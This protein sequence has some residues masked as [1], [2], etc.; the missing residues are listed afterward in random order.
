MAL[1][2]E[3]SLKTVGLGG[4]GLLTGAPGGGIAAEIRIAARGKPKSLPSPRQ[5]C[6]P[7]QGFTASSLAARAQVGEP[8]VF[9]ARRKSGNLVIAVS[10]RTGSR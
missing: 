2:D 10:R 3:F 9:W 4:E 6:G 5:G 1:L 8:E 7:G